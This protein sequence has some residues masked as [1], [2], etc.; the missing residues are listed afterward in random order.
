MSPDCAGQSH[1]EA[2]AARKRQKQKLQEQAG[3]ETA[4]DGTQAD[5]QHSG[6]KLSERG[7]HGAPA[8]AWTAAASRSTARS[9]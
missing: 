9:N 7:R 1:D 4:V 8:A 5:A 2:V 6:G 3:G